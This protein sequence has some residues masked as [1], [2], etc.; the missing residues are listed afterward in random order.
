MNNF[1]LIL[2][3][4]VGLFFGPVSTFLSSLP[5]A[6]VFFVPNRKNGATG[7]AGALFFRSGA[8]DHCILRR[9]GSFRP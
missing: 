3:S 9:A 5:E 4:M 2:I 8:G 6:R 1:G 7:L